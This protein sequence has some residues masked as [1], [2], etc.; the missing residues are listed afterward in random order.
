MART[1]SQT[2]IIYIYCTLTE[3]TCHLYIWD[4]FLRNQLHAGKGRRL[5]VQLLLTAADGASVCTIH[6]QW[7]HWHRSFTYHCY[8]TYQL[9]VFTYV[10]CTCYV[11]FLWHW[12]SE[13][14]SFSKR[15]FLSVLY[16][17]VSQLVHTY[18]HGRF[19]YVYMQCTILV[20]LVLWKAFLLK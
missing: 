17:H 16:L 12:S 3:G 7:R 11:Q 20:T 10:Y 15:I 13:K 14:P 19:T 5:P 2:L 6:S 8:Y 4:I 1:Y 9:V 18:Q